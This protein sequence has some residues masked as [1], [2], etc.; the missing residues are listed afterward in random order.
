MHKWYMAT[1]GQTVSDWMATVTEPSQAKRDKDVAHRVEEWLDEV[2]DLRPMGASTSKCDHKSTAIGT[3]AAQGIRDKMG[4][5][6]AKSVVED[7]AQKHS[8]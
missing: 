2:W 6:D 3:T 4:L 7:H 5:E 1:L 8:A